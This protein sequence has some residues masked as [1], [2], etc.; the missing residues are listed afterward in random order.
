MIIM[1]I[2]LKVVHTYR[3]TRPAG[4][5]DPIQT[6][7]IYLM[8]QLGTMNQSLRTVACHSQ[9]RLAKGKEVSQEGK[10]EKFLM[11]N[12]FII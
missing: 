11:N 7:L 5:P 2:L 1:K 10:K 9:R 12:I 8:D 6:M 4:S 3:L